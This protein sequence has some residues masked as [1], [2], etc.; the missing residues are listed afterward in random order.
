LDRRVATG[1]GVYHWNDGASPKTWHTWNVFASANER[2]PYKFY[3]GIVWRARHRWIFSDASGHARCPFWSWSRH[4]IR[5]PRGGLSGSSP[6]EGFGFRLLSTP[7]S[8]MA[9]AAGFGVHAASTINVGRRFARRAGGSLAHPSE[10]C[11]KALVRGAAARR[12]APS[13]RP[14]RQGAG[15]ADHEQ[16]VGDLVAGKGGGGG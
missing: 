12:P 1:V 3:G 2:P 14:A 15:I 9:T 11:V 4:R 10:S 16:D 6:E 13:G 5:E 7:L 8:L